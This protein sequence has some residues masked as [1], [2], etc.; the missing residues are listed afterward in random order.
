MSF[1]LGFG[2]RFELARS[3]FYRSITR[4]KIKLNWSM[5]QA[6]F[7]LNWSMTRTGFDSP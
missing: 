6:E 2:L 3:K 1:E 4:T 7:E 5:T